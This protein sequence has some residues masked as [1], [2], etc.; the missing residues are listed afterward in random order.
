MKAYTN[1]SQSKKLAEILPLESADMAW[2]NNSIRG[3]NYTD[4]YSANLYS[5]KE[6]QECFD[7]TLNGWDK[8]WKLIPCWSLAA[9]L[10]YLCEIDFFPSIETDEYG[11][12]MNVCYYDEEDGKLLHP[13]HDITAKEDNF[14]DAC[15]EMVIKL[16]EQKLL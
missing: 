3:V 12:T 6:M 1:I 16:N 8:Y 13:V 11:V 9:L 14:V 4:E 15:Y 7:E 10:N 2:C 5:V